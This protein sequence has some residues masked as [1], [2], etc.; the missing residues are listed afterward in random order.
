MKKNYQ[1]QC[2]KLSNDIP[3]ILQHHEG[4]VA[5]LYWWNKVGSQD[6]L[7]SQYGYA[8]ILEHMLFK[9]SGAKDSGLPSQGKMAKEIESLG[10]DVNAYTSF[11]QTVYHV[12]CSEHHLEKVLQIFGSIAK[13]ERFLKEDFSREKEVILEELKR[14]EDSP[15]RQMF[16]KA[17]E[18]TFSKEPYSRPIIGYKRTIKNSTVS[19]LEK[20][21]KDFYRPEN[22]GLILVGP[23]GVDSDRSKNLLKVIEKKFGKSVLKSTKGKKKKTE[24][25]RR[26][27]EQ[28]QP[29]A[30]CQPFDVTT[31]TMILSFKTPQIEHEDIPALDLLSSVL[32]MGEMCR[33]YQSL[34]YKKSLV[35]D[36]SAAVYTLSNSGMFYIYADFEKT[37]NA[38]KVA[39]TIFEQIKKIA[40]EGPSEEELKRVINNLESEKLYS[41]QSVDSMAGRLGFLNFCVENSNFDQEYLDRVKWVTKQKIQ[42]VAKKYLNASK[43]N[44][45]LM[46]S[47]SE[48]VKIEKSVITAAKKT[49]S[50]SSKLGKTNKKS[51]QVSNVANVIKRKSGLRVV[52]YERPNS[53]VFSAHV[54]LLGGTRLENLK[55]WGASQLLAMTW[56]KG[57]RDKKAQEITKIIEGAA[58]GIEG[59]SGRNT[60]GL[61]VT[62][63]QRDW[64]KLS[65]LFSEILI[66]PTFPK[67]ELLH[68]KRVTEETIN[69]VQDHSAKLCNKIFLETLFESHPYGRSIYGSLGSVSNI[70]SSQLIKLHKSW[71]KPESM[72]LSVS[73]PITSDQ[74]EMLIEQVERPFLNSSFRVIDNGSSLVNEEEPL[75]GPRWVYENLNR[76]QVHI[77][78]GGLG[79]SIKHKD[80]MPLRILQT[81]L[82]GQSGRLFIELREKQSLA[83]TVA[84]VGF[85]GIERGFVG[86]YIACSPEKKEQSISGIHKVLERFCKKGPSKA[87]MKRAQEYYLGSRSMELQGDASLAI[88]NGL[89]LLLTQQLKGETDIVKLVRSVKP[90]DLKR[91]CEKYLLNAK[92]A[93]CVVG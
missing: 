15:G 3:V 68:S 43:M 86:T 53:H 38:L 31:P 28:L 33:L 13:P 36:V 67:D 70:T 20:F 26:L 50:F 59:A 76:E 52:H 87:E 35:T 48:K 6:E 75:K 85:E 65:H 90:E 42:D 11:D 21:Y 56:T 7:P 66:N 14:S 74:L 49:I 73:G 57:T 72:V 9:D 78:V 93:T 25:K 47:K 79:V 63:L 16:Q 62:G 89:E 80:K 92:M 44:F 32:G 82:G 5:S 60:L 41:T 51:N 1:P 88:C 81:V 23:I 27:K 19:Q 22:M 4:A 17:F 54:S 64:D 46:H 30:L 71:V 10:G 77:L 45:V 69:G 8:H 40:N 29:Q 61:Q 18:L 24:K 91:V 39:E 55:N 34:F 37:E 84:P 2:I 83:Y 58:A 12:T